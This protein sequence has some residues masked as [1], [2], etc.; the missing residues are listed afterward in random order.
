VA[1]VDGFD[2]FGTDMDTEVGTGE[3]VLDLWIGEAE[4]YELAIS[5]LMGQNYYNE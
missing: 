3:N 5:Q 4:Y 1:E 2:E